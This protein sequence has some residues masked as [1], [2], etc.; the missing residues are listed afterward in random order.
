MK[1]IERDFHLHPVP[2]VPHNTT[3]P[4]TMTTNAMTINMDDANLPTE[5]PAWEAMLEHVLTNASSGDLYEAIDAEWVKFNFDIGSIYDNDEIVDYVQEADIPI[6]EIYNDEE[7]VAYAKEVVVGAVMTLQEIHDMKI[8][9]YL[10]GTRDEREANANEVRTL[11]KEIAEMREKN[12]KP[13]NK[14]T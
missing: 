8:E 11:K 5:G 2:A 7:V 1:K 6:G 14:P 3:T 4:T 13:T 12:S 10:K 9:E